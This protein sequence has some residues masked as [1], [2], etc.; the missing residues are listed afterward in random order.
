MRSVLVLLLLSFAVT[1]SFSQADQSTPAF[2][3]YQ[4][5][6]AYFGKLYQEKKFAEAAE[7]LENAIDKYPD[8]LLA[9]SYNLAI[10]Y[11]YLDRCREGVQV[12]LK[13]LEQ[14]VF[15]N[16]WA[17]DR[18]L[19]NPYRELESFQ[20]VL[21]GNEKAKQ[22][23]QKSAKPDLLVITPAGYDKDRRYPLFIAL[24]GGGGSIAGFKDRWTS[25]KLEND[26]IVAFVQSSQ[27]VSMTGFNWTEDIEISKREIAE[28]FQKVA[29][30]YPIDREQVIIGGFSSGGVASLEVAFCNTVPVSGFIALCPARPESV[31]TEAVARARKAGLCG[32]ILTTEMDPRLAE[33]KEMIELFKTEG[34]EHRFIVTPD[35]GHWFPKDLNEQIDESIDHISSNS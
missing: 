6:R 16:K 8:Q 18:E 7:I 13:A 15:F 2:A 1:G 29:A 3:D 10:V 21:A 12:L 33:Q 24:H 17:F 26:Y 32:T 31:T 19:W 4:E 23:A 22:E 35:I 34:F 28:A 25:D 30:D 27:V 9:N 14:G 5:M 11:G 20:A